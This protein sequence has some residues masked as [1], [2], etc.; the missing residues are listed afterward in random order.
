[1]AHLIKQ[2][3]DDYAAPAAAAEGRAAGREVPAKPVTLVC[4]PHERERE[5]ERAAA[6]EYEL[7]SLSE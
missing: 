1:M 3:D 6:G 4:S 5:R 7:F 2:A